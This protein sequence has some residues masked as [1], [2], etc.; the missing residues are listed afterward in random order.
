[1]KF[2]ERIGKKPIKEMIQLDSMDDE[3]RNSLWNIVTF[4]LIQPL[5]QK[6][7]LDGSEYNKIIIKIWFSLFKEPTDQISI[8]T[9]KVAEE[10]RRRFFTRDYLYVYDFIDFLA[11]QNKIFPNVNS[12]IEH[13]NSVLEKELS[14]YRFIN[15]QLAPVTSEIEIL[16]IETALQS[17]T[18]QGLRGVEIHLEEALNKLSD[19]KNPDYRNSIKESISAVEAICRV[20]TRESTLG[21]ALNSLDSKG[22]KINGQLKSGFEKIYAFTN[23]KQSGIRHAIMEDHKN[24]D[25][26]DAKYMLVASSSFINYLMGKCKTLG[27]TIQ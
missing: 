19:R 16:E 3:L 7:W 26:E 27:I 12:F 24:P 14:G 6:Q 10:L 25:F 1:M 4:F 13:C 22:I 21:K 2:S 17:T 18:E 15:E 20:L 23:D 5:K 9:E 11:S 8:S